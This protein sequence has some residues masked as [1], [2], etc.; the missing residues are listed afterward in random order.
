MGE[1]REVETVLDFGA[2][3]LEQQWR[4]GRL[5]TVEPAV[6]AF[7]VHYEHVPLCRA[8]LAFVYAETGD[9]ARLHEQVERIARD[10]FADVADGGDRV[11]TFTLAAIALAAAGDREQAARLRTLLE[12]YAARR[13]TAAGGTVSLG[14]VVGYVGMLSVAAGD[15]RRGLRELA[16]GAEAN[17]VDGDIAWAAR[18]LLERARAL[19]DAGA[20]GSAAACAA[21]GRAL[22]ESAEMDWLV[23]RFD[24]LVPEAAG[25]R[26]EMRTGLLDG[27][28]PRR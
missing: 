15:V 4:S 26:V 7:A 5:E 14:S 27:R 11:L 9:A 18:L 28:S 19:A 12:P 24:A 10:G 3:L 17:V 20:D 1:P 22:A 25:A 23:E 2:R 13:A 8:A 16:A 21:E 6:R